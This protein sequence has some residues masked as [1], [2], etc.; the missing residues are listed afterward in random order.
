[1]FTTVGIVVMQAAFV[2]VD[3][4]YNKNVNGF[5][6]MIFL[7]KIV[8]PFVHLLE[9]L[10]SFAFLAMAF[11][12]FFKIV[13]AGGDDEK[14]KAGKQ[15]IISA[16][17]GFIIMKLPALIVKGIY[18]EASCDTPLLFSVCRIKD[19]NLSGTISIMTNVINYINGFLAIVIV[20]LV[21]YAGW[22]VLSSGGDEEK[23]KKAKNILIYIV[24]GVVLLVSSYLL[25]NFFVLKD[26]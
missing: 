23:I 2:I 16:L 17:I 22:L 7:D 25:F 14:V 4:L 3:T 15:T 19:P 18:G 6:S 21:L 24:I 12:A 5:A 13:T 26:A 20:L 8:Y 10:A 1:M 9:M 11:Y